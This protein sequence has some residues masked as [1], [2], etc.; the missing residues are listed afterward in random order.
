[1]VEIKKK[2]KRAHNDNEEYLKIDKKEFK[3]KY[4]A[5]SSNETP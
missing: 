1:L 4:R 3:I 2:E 5:N